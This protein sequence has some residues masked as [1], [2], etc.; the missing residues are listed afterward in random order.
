LGFHSQDGT[1][2]IDIVEVVFA[3]AADKNI[4]EVPVDADLVEV[5]SV[6]K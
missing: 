4:A 6:F 2:V 5:Y 1:K 3:E